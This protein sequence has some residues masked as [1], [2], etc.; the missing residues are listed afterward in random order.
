MERTDW[1]DGEL[2]S[3]EARLLMITAITHHQVSSPGWGADEVLKL[4]VELAE[5]DRTATK[6]VADLRIDTF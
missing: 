2:S 3:A 5:I 4:N 6:L 1:L